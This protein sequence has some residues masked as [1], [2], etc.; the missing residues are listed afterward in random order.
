MLVTVMLATVNLLK[1]VFVTFM[2][3]VVCQYVNVKHDMIVML[4]TVP[5]VT[6]VL[7]TIM[8]CQGQSS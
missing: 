3:I 4:V 1:V 6:V 5:L 8:L 2:I 7:V